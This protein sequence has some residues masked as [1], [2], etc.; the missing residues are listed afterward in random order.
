[1]LRKWDLGPTKKSDILSWIRDMKPAKSPV[2]QQTRMAAVVF[3]D[4]VG[5]SKKSVPAQLAAKDALTVLLRR[6]VTSYPKEGRVVLDTGD[7]AAVGFLVSPE[8]ALGLALRLRHELIGAPADALLKT[9]DLR[10]GIN[11]GPLKVVTDVNGQPNM[12]GEGINSAERIMSFA[13]P[14][15]TTASR[16]FQEAVSY[17]DPSFQGLFEPLGTRADK[18]GREHEVFRV[19]DATPAIDAALQSLGAGA[20]APSRRGRVAWPARVALAAGVAA[21]IVA[22]G[23]WMA[24]SSRATSTPGAATPEAVARPAASA[25]AP[26]TSNASAPPR[27]EATP[28][29]A[30][31]PPSS[32]ATP[33][34][35]PGAVDATGAAAV[36]PATASTPAA[37]PA[38]TPPASSSAAPPDKPAPRDTRPAKKAEPAPAK[39]ALAGAPAAAKPQPAARDAASAV[40][41][42]CALLLQRATVGETLTPEEQREMAKSCR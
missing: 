28:A 4:L 22:A 9:G 11:L 13:E 8:F 25:P 39:S 7:G 23:A 30:T 37:P 33:A 31:A 32:A 35:A 19:S 29:P 40:S 6:L 41:P 17:L 26:P 14:G 42:R 10:L 24:W 5:F 3:A 21:V 36:T 18:H 20:A 16:S 34:P 38:V 12:V 2:D 27:P 1:V 15:Q